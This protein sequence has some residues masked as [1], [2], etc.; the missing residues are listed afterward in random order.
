VSGV[1]GQVTSGLSMV[2]LGLVLRF[3]PGRDAF[4][5]LAAAA[6]ALAAT[7]ALAPEPRAQAHPDIERS[8]V[9]PDSPPTP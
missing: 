4:I 7:V 3:A 5:V 9:P 1:V 2:W 6:A 8:L